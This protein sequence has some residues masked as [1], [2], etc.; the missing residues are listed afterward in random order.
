MRFWQEWSH[1][2]YAVSIILCDPGIAGNMITIDIRVPAN[3]GNCFIP[4][5][6]LILEDGIRNILCVL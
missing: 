5:S 6:S 1:M 4:L 3:I 2:D